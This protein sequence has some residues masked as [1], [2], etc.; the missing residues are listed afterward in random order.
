MH[1]KRQHRGLSACL[2]SPTGAGE[3]MG[4]IVAAGKAGSMEIWGCRKYPRNCKELKM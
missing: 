1:L 4:V 2:G 3:G